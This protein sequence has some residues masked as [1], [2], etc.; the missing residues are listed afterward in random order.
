M[1]RNK[2]VAPFILQGVHVNHIDRGV[3]RGP[4]S[5][6]GGSTKPAATLPPPP[7]GG[8]F[9]LPLATNKCYAINEI[10]LV[11]TNSFFFIFTITFI[12]RKEILF[13]KKAKE[14]KRTI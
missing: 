10:S 9:D 11:H 6:G 2:G 13:E 1:H 7:D 5:K 3:F 14:R 8:M 12:S 4:G